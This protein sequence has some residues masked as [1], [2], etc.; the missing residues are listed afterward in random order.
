MKDS[1]APRAPACGPLASLSPGGTPDGC[2]VGS[3]LFPTHPVP[4]GRAQP[5]SLRGDDKHRAAP[6]PRGRGLHA[7]S[8]CTWSWLRVSGS[9]GAAHLPWAPDTGAAQVQSAFPPAQAQMSQVVSVSPA[10][11][12]WPA[13]IGN[14][15][16]TRPA[17]FVL[18][19]V[20]WQSGH[21]YFGCSPQLCSRFAY[22]A[23]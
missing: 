21:K 3:F 12:R 18:G 16:T 17:K 9:F 1:R 20:W 8:G 4:R 14:V 11:L 7:R 13:S 22:P 5:C 23:L 10:Q 15:S 6:S 19:G 2:L